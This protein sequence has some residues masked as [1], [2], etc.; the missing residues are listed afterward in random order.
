MIKLIANELQYQAILSMKVEEQ[1]G[2]A[3]NFMAIGDKVKTTRTDY[4]EGAKAFGKVACALEV[5]LNN[6]KKVSAFAPNKSLAEFITDITGQKPPTHALTL[7]NAFGSF[8]LTGL[9]TETDY[10]VNSNNCLELAARIVTEVKGDIA[11]DAVAKAAAQLKQRGDKEAANLRALLASLKPVKQMTAEE[12]LEAY[13]EIVAS[14]HLGAC[15]AQLPDEIAALPEAMQKEIYISIS[16]SIFRLDD[17]LG[18]TTD[19]WA[20]EAGKTWKPVEQPVQ[21]VNAGAPAGN[22][23]PSTPAAPENDE[24]VPAIDAEKADTA[25]AET[26]LVEA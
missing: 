26:E 21:I 20:Q 4:K 13:A 25:K 11:H 22:A 23:A 6:G 7:K 24:I 12:A 18:S 15:H 10:D 2:L 16:H 8:V 1:D 14:G 19:A 3:K 9:M 17:K 5:R